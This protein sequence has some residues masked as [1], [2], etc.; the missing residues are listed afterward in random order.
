MKKILRKVFI[1]LLSFLF[2]SAPA[3]HAYSSVDKAAGLGQSPDFS[4]S[5]VSGKTVSLEDSRG[6]NVVLFFFTTWCPWCRKKFPELVKNQE[7]YKNDGVELIIIDAG[8][9]RAKVL[10]FVQK[11]GIPFDILLDVDMKVSEDYDIVGIPAFVLI[12]EDGRILYR[13]NDMP[14]NYKKIFGK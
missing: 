14:D 13:D 4:L 9:S 10:S 11:Q 8:E 7:R 12:S 3:V 1:V 6:K 2:L 5:T